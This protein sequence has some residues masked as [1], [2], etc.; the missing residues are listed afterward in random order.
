MLIVLIEAAAAPNFKREIV[1]APNGH[2]DREAEREREREIEMEIN[3]LGA[4]DQ[5]KSR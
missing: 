4:D 1:R 2:R 3:I 5:Y